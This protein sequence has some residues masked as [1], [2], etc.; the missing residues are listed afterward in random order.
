LCKYAGVNRS[1]F[2][3]GK[4]EDDLH[5]SNSLSNVAKRRTTS[6]L[7]I[8]GKVEKIRMTVFLPIPGKVGKTTQASILS[9]SK[10]TQPS[11]LI[12]PVK[13]EKI[14]LR[15]LPPISKGDLSP[16]LKIPGKSG[17]NTNDGTFA[18]S[19]QKW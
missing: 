9:I 12:I 5:S 10:T 14:P 8:P 18:N 15:V 13:V 1:G 7:P 19:G 17:K 2:F 6:I 16:L 3:I 11:I 4:K